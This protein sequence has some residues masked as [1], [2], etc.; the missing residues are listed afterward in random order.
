MKNLL[1]LTHPNL[2]QSFSNKK[3]VEALQGIAN[4]KIRNLNNDYPNFIIDVEKEQADLLSHDRVIL[5]FPMFWYSTPALL[6]EWLDAVLT[7]GFAYSYGNNSE[8]FKLQGKKLLLS[9]TAAGPQNAYQGGAVNLSTVEELFIPLNR[10]AHYC[11]MDFE[12]PVVSH[13]MLGFLPHKQLEVE[14]RVEAHIEKL[15]NIITQEVTAGV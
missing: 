9:I 4:L 8:D 2:Q 15:K 3:I 10:T 5:Q 7:P 13:E 14:N 12:T 6:K 11:R 1:I